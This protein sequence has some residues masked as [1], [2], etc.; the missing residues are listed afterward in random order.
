MAGG[1]HRHALGR[2]H[3]FPP[4]NLGY[5]EIPP[6]FDWQSDM[7]ATLAV[8]LPPIQMQWPES[9]AGD[10]EFLR[11]L[12]IDASDYAALHYVAPQTVVAVEMGQL[13]R[14]NAGGLIRDDRDFL[15]RIA[16]LAYEWYGRRRQALTIS[17]RGATPFGKVGELIT[18]LGTGA[19]NE[20]IRT[21]ITEVRIDFA[22]NATDTHKT[23]IQTQWSEMD[24]L[25]MIL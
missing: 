23:T 11:T 20:P 8:V 6:T 24:V 10:P 14:T 4:A 1:D 9:A 16:R 5:D 3:Y 17:Y 12:T 21:V 22:Q 19:T 15:R 2:G 25:K 13:I 18:E 7:L